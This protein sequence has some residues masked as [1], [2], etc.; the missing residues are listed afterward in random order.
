[1]AKREVVVGDRFGTWTIIKKQEDSDK[2]NYS[3]ECKCD[4][5]NDRVF[6]K[7]AL[8]YGTYG[9]CKK[10]KESDLNREKLLRFK[11][12]AKRV[13]SYIS[14]DDNIDKDDS[15]KLKCIDGHT[16]IS[17]FNSYKG[18]IT[19][20]RIES[21]RKSDIKKALTGENFK[22]TQPYFS[23][24][25]NYEKNILTPE[26]V[27]PCSRDEY[28]FD[29]ECGNEFKESPLNI[30]KGRGCP[31]CDNK[32]AESR[33]ATYTKELCKRI[34]TNVKCEN[35]FPINTT[36]NG[37]ET[38]LFPDVILDDLKINIEIHGKQHYVFT[39]HW[40]KTK[41]NFLKS[42]QRDIA[43]KEWLEYNGYVQIVVN[44]TDDLEEDINKVN[45]I[46]RKILNI[47]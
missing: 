47:N 30:R 12:D 42:L 28:W 24:M 31:I 32:G 39:P 17:S 37:Y 35:E 6:T 1:M 23:N 34:F 2:Y 15:F 14:I 27:L 10:C 46:I 4:C 21:K 45:D 5:G 26:E 41:Q 33:L 43:K 9:T 22:N 11:E 7:Y 8:I 36:V 3:Y 13:N 38:V 29:C 25:W 20:K 44:V 18:C 40:H 19:C 16:Y